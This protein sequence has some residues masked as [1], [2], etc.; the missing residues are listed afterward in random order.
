M[1]NI[2][3]I[4]PEVQAFIDRE[5][6]QF[7][8]GA[9]VASS[10][11][12]RANVYNPATGEVLATVALGSLADMDKAVQVA[13]QAFVDRRWYDMRPTEREKVLYR[14]SE[15][16]QSH[17]EILAQLETLN[18]GKSIHISR[19]IEV[20]ATAEY[21]RYMAGWATKITGETFDVSIPVPAGARYTASTRREPIG[22]VAS[23][24]P[25]N[26]PLAIS[27]WKTIPALVAGCP[28]VLK[29]ALETPLTAL[30][31][32]QLALEAGIPAGVFNVIT[33]AGEV[34]G[35][36]LAEHPLVRK[37]SF[38][39]STAVGKRVGHAAI[40]NMTR[41]SLELGG[42]NPAIMLA[43]VQVEQAVAG[44]LMGG[45]LNSG[46]VCAASSRL[47]VHRSK[48]NAVSE[49]ISAAVKGMSVG[50][51]MDMTAQ[52]NPM[53]T[54][55]HQTSVCRYLDIAKQQGAQIICGGGKAERAGYF[56]E[57]T[58]IIG[59]AAHDTIM[60][61]EVFGP[62]MAIVPFDTVDEAIALANDSV[63]G[64][65]ASLWTNDLTAMHNIVPRIEAGT[66]WVN[67]HVP[68]DPSMPFGGFKQSGMGREFGKGSVEAFTE[69]KSICIAH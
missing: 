55:K 16:L 10:S 5:H 36:G 19:A 1:S 65:A 18:Q 57:P 63:Y 23:I 39:G 3:A 58:V 60:T 4:L 26:F 12:E 45:M 38:T 33:G 35:Q 68:L 6:Q 31:L 43:D 59:A 50:A 25:W 56:V 24:A 66:V 40:D 42:K 51:G 47:Y 13:H 62:V 41:F 53:T 9:W 48:F 8:N 11:T 61:E 15:L 29:P 37:I 34:I 49:A 52:I 20:G 32:A 27:L 46:Q 54:L 28:V 69:I 2:V 7:I 21:V 30:Y 17:G 67:T 64:L 14:F 44:A 22:V